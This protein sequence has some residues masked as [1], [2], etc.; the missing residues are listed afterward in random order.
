MYERDWR[1]FLLKG[2]GREPAIAQVSPQIVAHLGAASHFVHLHHAYALKAT[3]K[4][5]MHPRELA[6]IWDTIERGVAIADRPGHVTF[7]MRH[8]GGQW[9]QVTVK[10]AADTRR[11]YVS[12]FYKL[13]GKD[14]ERKLKRGEA[15]RL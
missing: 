15:L 5:A 14:A 7:Y 4:H 3:I 2:H 8:A 13:R 10:C 12:T 9:L 6:L 11:M 1:E